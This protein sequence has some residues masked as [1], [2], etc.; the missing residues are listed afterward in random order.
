MFHPP[1]SFDGQSSVAVGDGDLQDVVVEVALLEGRQWRAE[2][3][4][5]TTTFWSFSCRVLFCDCPR[6]KKK[7]SLNPSILS[8]LSTARFL[9]LSGAERTRTATW[10]EEESPA[11]KESTSSE[12]CPSK[13]VIIYEMLSHLNG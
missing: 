5:G 7:W 1:E 8:C 13:K 11:G 9:K 6:R 3:R 12:G 10:E 4:R 2:V